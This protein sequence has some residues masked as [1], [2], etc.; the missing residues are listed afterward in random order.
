[1][2]RGVTI[3]VALKTWF[4]VDHLIILNLYTIIHYD[5]C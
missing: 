1:M 5:K 3:I 4:N 2:K